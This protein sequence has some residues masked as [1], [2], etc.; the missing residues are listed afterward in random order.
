[1]IPT[2]AYERERNKTKVN[3]A[4]T[5]VNYKIA[6]HVRIFG[7]NLPFR[8]HYS[9]ESSHWIQKISSTFFLTS[10][11]VLLHISTNFIY[12]FGLHL[13]VIFPKFGRIH[14]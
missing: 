14:L 2:D 1:M 11:S 6:H 7:Q 8:R 13:I 9:H 4:I 12:L 5:I 10:R 3:S